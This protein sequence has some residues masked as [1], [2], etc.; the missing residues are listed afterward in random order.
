MDSD[1]SQVNARTIWEAD[2]VSSCPEFQWVG[3][4]MRWHGVFEEG[5][6]KVAGDI[7]G[8]KR[9]KFI[10]NNTGWENKVVLPNYWHSREGHTRAKDGTSKNSLVLHI[11]HIKRLIE[12]IKSNK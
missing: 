3:N 1:V 7:I 10:I 8:L 6:S 2:D 12:A 11:N 9:L 5:N 4:L